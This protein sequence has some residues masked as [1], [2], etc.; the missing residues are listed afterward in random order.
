MFPNFSKFS[1]GCPRTPL[2]DPPFRK[3]G[4]A[5]VKDSSLMIKICARACFVRVY[6]KQHH[7]QCGELRLHHNNKHLPESRR[8][9]KNGLDKKYQNYSKRKR[10]SEKKLK[11]LEMFRLEIICILLIFERKNTFLR[12][13]KFSSII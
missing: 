6:K 8:S 1:G 11:Q 3:T 5:P 9:T 7:R 13:G 10:N 4:S 2:E 12:F